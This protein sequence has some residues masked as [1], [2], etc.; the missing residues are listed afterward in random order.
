MTVDAP[1][2]HFE[3]ELERSGQTIVLRQLARSLTRDIAAEDVP[4]YSQ[5][6][7]KVQQ[8]AGYALGLRMADGGDNERRERLRKLL[9]GD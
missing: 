5:A 6:I 3:Q 9:Q 8:H 7:A 4:K 1:G 2:F